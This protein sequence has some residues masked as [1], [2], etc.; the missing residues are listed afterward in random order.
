MSEDPGGGLD[1][2]LLIAGVGPAGRCADLGVRFAPAPRFDSVVQDEGAGIHELVGQKDGTGAK[3]SEALREILGALAGQHHCGGLLVGGLGWERDIELHQSVVPDV[4][5]EGV[6][7]LGEGG[8]K[9][10]NTPADRTSPPRLRDE[11]ELGLAV[12]EVQ[13]DQDV[14]RDALLYV[15]NLL[16]KDI[17]KIR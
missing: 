4:G 17:R 5:D 16:S 10:L 9:G 12:L 13:A 11:G 2:D 7:S 8:F 15:L 6:L 14:V 3:G 1:G